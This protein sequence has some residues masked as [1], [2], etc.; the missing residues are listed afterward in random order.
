[1]NERGVLGRLPAGLGAHRRP[2]AVRH[3]P[4]VHRRRAHDRGGARAQLAGARRTG[5]DRAGG[6]RT[7]R[8]SAVAPRAVHGDDAAR[9]RQGPRRRSF[10]TRRRTGA[11]G[12]PGDRPV[13]GGDRDGVLAGAAP[14]PAQPDRV[15]TRHRRPEDHPRP[16]RGD[17]VARAAAAAAGADGGRHAGGVQQGVERLEGDAAARAVCAGGRGAGR[18]AV[19]RRAR[20]ARAARPRGGRRAADRLAAGGRRTIPFARL[21]RVLAGLRSGDARPPRPADPR[22]RCA[23]RAADG[24]NAAA[25]GA[26]GDR[27]DRV[28]RRPCRAVQPD[29]R[30]AG[31]GRRLDRRC[32]HPHA[33]QRHGAGHVLDPGRRRRRVRRAAPAGPAVRADRAGA[34][35]AASGSAPRSARCP[36]RC[37]AGGCARSMCRRAW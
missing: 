9:H 25:A 3:L 6:V 2:D 21:W 12:R 33:D 15:Q 5:A 35:R 14:P 18:R 32:A 19:H 13:G 23:P 1:M 27:S 22:C 28:R 17:P 20:R 8:T 37:W 36:R 7:D 11:G 29:R 10:R 26:G 4:R 31:G 16:R 30:R 34:V 24:G